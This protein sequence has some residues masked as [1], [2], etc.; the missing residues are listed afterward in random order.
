M[1]P[2]EGHKEPAPRAIKFRKSRVE[3]TI[4]LRAESDSRRCERDTAQESERY[5]GHFF[6]PFSFF[7][8]LIQDVVAKSL[9]AV[10]EREQTGVSHGS[11]RERQPHYQPR[12]L[13][14]YGLQLTLAL[15]GGACLDT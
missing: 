15:V 6:L 3:T 13:V 4:W 2:E 1:Q 5:L 8:F 12:L 10:E 9:C 14:G 7:L 11:N